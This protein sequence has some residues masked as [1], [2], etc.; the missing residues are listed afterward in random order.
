MKKVFG[1]VLALVL[2]LSMTVMA[3]PVRAAISNIN[4][5]VSNPIAGQPSVYTITFDMQQPVDGTTNEYFDIGFPSGTTFSGVL[6]LADVTCPTGPFSVTT[7]ATTVRI[8]PNGVVVPGTITITIGNLAGVWVINPPPGDYA[9]CVGTSQ[10]T[11]VCSDASDAKV[12][13]TYELAM[14]V[15]PAGGGT[16][17][18]E[19]NESPYEEGTAVSIKAVAAAGYQFVSWEAPAG[20]FAD[21]NAA[22]TTFTMPDDDITVT[23][24]F[25]AVYE[26]TISSATGGS[27]T[28]PGEGTFVYDD[29]TVVSLVATQASGY[30]FVKWTGDVATIANANAASTTITMQGNYSITA[31]FEEEEEPPS[32]PTGGCFIATA[33]YG[34]PMAEEIQI[35]R[36]FRDEYLLT[37]PLGQALVDLYY[38]VSPPIAE[39]I[40]EHPGLKPVV[41]AGLLPAVVMSTIAVNTSP[42]EKAAILGLLVLVSVVLTVWAARRRSR[43]PEYSA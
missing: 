41:R 20:I 4:V 31:N 34:T 11:A 5:T 21:A 32:S 30:Q 7:I 6:G 1:I 29:G 42:A 25:V 3:I 13:A 9:L 17:T 28:T 39:F 27:V 33:A 8:V 10:E 43:G 12:V 23:A 37:N 40:T 26:L 36:K 18:D 2:V 19:T 35:L 15:D 16:A 22:E 24:N 14:A 38:K